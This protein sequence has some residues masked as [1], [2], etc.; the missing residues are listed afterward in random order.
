MCFGSIFIICVILIISVRSCVFPFSAFL[1]APG[2]FRP[3]RRSLALVVPS[4]RFSFLPV[5]LHSFSGL[6]RFVCSFRSLVA[7]S[8]LSCAQ[9]VRFHSPRPGIL[10]AF[11]ESTFSD[12]VH[13]ALIQR[14]PFSP[15]PVPWITFRRCTSHSSLRTS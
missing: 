7:L 14:A 8:P 10:R 5:A 1:W 15:F 2:G 12:L 13:P 9:D 4:C 3:L 11:V 6:W